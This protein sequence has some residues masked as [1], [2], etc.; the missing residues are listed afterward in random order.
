MNSIISELFY[1]S[2]V[3]RCF[4]SIEHMAYI[5]KKIV[6]HLDKLD[7]L[8]TKYSNLIY[9]PIDRFQ[10]VREN[11]LKKADLFAFHM[12]EHLYFHYL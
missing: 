2:D 5:L 1:V 4:L 6:K 7:H 3:K 11:L 9:T 8:F 10:V 12:K